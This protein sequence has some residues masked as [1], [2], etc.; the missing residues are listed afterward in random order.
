[1]KDL[2]YTF[3]IDEINQIVN[4]LPFFFKANHA[5]VFGLFFFSFWSKLCKIS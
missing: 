3:V 2:L 1:M 4:P 5:S